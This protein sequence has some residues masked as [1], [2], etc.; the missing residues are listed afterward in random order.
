MSDIIDAANDLVDAT[1]ART[2]AW[3]RH[4]AQQIEPGQPGECDLCGEWAGRLV[5]GICAPCRDR[6]HLP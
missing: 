6:H 3:Q 1:L 2:V 4:Q 5:G